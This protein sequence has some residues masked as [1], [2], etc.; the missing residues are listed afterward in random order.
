MLAPGPAPEDPRSPSTAATLAEHHA[1]DVTDQAVALGRRQEAAGCHQTSVRLV[2]EAQQRLVVRYR[3]PR[4]A[5]F[6]PALQRDD[7]LVVQHE[8]VLREGTPQPPQP[9]PPVQAR[10]REP[11]RLRSLLGNCRIAV[12][13]RQL[14][15]T[16]EN[17]WAS[18]GDR[19]GQHLSDGLRRPAAVTCARSP[20]PAPA[21]GLLRPSPPASVGEA[22]RRPQ[23]RADPGYGRR[24]RSEMTSSSAS[25]TKFMTTEDPP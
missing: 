9:G 3:P 1:V 25:R 7:R 6:G 17:P 10:R 5:I 2:G 14:A 16:Q 21:R 24:A 8:Q 11:L 15:R 19:R 4:P 22:A 18:A 13:G 12:V 23:E 20:V